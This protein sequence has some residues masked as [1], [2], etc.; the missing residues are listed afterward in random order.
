MSESH[1]DLTKHGKDANHIDA[2]H[3]RGAERSSKQAFPYLGPKMPRVTLTPARMRGQGQR[4][5]TAGTLST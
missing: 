1:A 2:S 3:Q 5:A 4:D